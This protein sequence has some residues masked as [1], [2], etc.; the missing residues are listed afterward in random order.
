MDI[1]GDLKDEI[2]IESQHGAGSNH[3]IEDIRIFKDDYHKLRLIF[4]ILTL[5]SYFGLKPPHNQDTISKVE[6]TEQTSEN[7]GVRD[8]IVKSK[9]IYYK[10]NENKTID[11]EEYLGTKIYRWDGKIF[12]EQK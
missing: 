2:I 1:D 9:T 3:Y 4:S 12:E 10:D 11:K 6:F 8:I 7:K 5:D